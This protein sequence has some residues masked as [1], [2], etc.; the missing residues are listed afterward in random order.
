MARRGRRGGVGSGGCAALGGKARADGLGTGWGRAGDTAPGGAQTSGVCL[1]TS[2]KRRWRKG[3][4][5][6][7]SGT[8]LGMGGSVSQRKKKEK[9]TRKRKEKKKS[10]VWGFG[11]EMN[12]GPEVCL[13]RV[14][15]LRCVRDVG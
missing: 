1:L 4:E 10:A 13:L 9:K 11:F 14:P 7:E 6:P 3:A 2:G 12:V 8:G 15:W 5:R